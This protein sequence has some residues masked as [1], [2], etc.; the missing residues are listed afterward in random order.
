M[1]RNSDDW[2]VLKAVNYNDMVE[3]NK[4]IDKE[5]YTIDVLSWGL[6]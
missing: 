5:N 4:Y 1:S 6:L 3:F 2:K